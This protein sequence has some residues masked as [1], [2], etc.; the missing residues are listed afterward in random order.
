MLYR[1]GDFAVEYRGTGQFV[2]PNA[3]VVGRVCL[4]E[5]TSVWFNATVRGDIE[6]IHI[7]PETNIQD[8]AVLHTD[9]GC[10]LTFGR[11]VTV[12]HHAM[13]HGCTVGDFSL[14]GI[15]AV[16]LNKVTIG[17]HCLIGANTLIPEGK[18][19][20]DGSLVMGSPGKVVRMLTDA[21]IERLHV[22][23]QSYADRAQQYLAQLSVQ[24]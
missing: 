17:K 16:V 23:A 12:G 14:I 6:L 9:L 5:R 4:E 2:A 19:I 15:H 18:V 24:L 3:A 13:V 7:G 10:P 8:N 11:G 20:P 21:E 22:S 1:F